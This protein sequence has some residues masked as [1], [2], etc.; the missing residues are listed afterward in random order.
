MLPVTFPSLVSA[1]AV[2]A[3]AAV[4]GAATW[5]RLPRAFRGPSSGV[6]ASWPSSLRGCWAAP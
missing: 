5:E 6:S 4:V 1:A 3:A 2:A